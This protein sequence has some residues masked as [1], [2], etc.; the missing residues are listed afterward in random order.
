MLSYSL[1]TLVSANDV[2][3]FLSV[4]PLLFFFSDLLLLIIKI[5]HMQVNAPSTM[6]T[7]ITPIT[8]MKIAVVDT[9][10]AE[11]V[12]KNE[13]VDNFCSTSVLSSVVECNKVSITSVTGV[14]FS[15]KASKVVSI[16]V[17]VSKVTSAVIKTCTHLANPYFFNKEYFL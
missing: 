5:M 2:F 4:I 16:G 14:L 12:V 1:F 9:E 3:T 10:V 8:P 7:N 15:V 11:V 13:C 17:S 6:T